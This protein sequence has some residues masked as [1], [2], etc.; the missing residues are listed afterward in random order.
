MVSMQSLGG[1][2]KKLIVYDFNVFKCH[3]VALCQS[4]GIEA[5]DFGL[6]RREID[7]LPNGVVDDVRELT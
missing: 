1:E 5:K 6:D 3:A 4:V 2:K 7:G